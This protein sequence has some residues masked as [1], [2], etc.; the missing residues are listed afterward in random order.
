MGRKE[1]QTFPEEEKEIGL[2]TSLA[3]APKNRLGLDKAEPV[4]WHS[5]VKGFAHIKKDARL[6]R[7]T[8]GPI[9]PPF[10]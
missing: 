8:G 10:V 5:G 6:A 1:P 4:T 3:G 9:R 2:R 7:P